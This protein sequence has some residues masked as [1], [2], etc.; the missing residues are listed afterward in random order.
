MADATSTLFAICCIAVWLH[1][2]YHLIA[3][4]TDLVRL[5]NTAVRFN[6]LDTNTFK[7]EY[8]FDNQAVVDA[9]QDGCIQ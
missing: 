7:T 9:L 6:Y 8:L 2:E 5:G 4:L 1:A 3:G